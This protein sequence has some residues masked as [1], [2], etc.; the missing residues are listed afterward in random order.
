ML[1]PGYRSAFQSGA[2]PMNIGIVETRPHYRRKAMSNN[3]KTL[4]TNGQ[5]RKDMTNNDCF[6]CHQQG[7]WAQKY[8]DERFKTNRAKY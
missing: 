7:C 4:E 2:E 8:K 5:V 1:N 6:V 3:P